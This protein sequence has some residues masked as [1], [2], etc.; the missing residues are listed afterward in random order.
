MVL[1]EV[2][3]GFTMAATLDTWE[4][5]SY[6]DTCVFNPAYKHLEN[7]M[8]LQLRWA[9]LGYTS[10]VAARSFIYHYKGEN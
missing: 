3:N 7:E 10:A 1:P 9:L 5:G 2:L 6:N 8:E 4:R